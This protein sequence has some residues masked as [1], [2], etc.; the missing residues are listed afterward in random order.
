MSASPF[1]TLFHSSNRSARV[2]PLWNTATLL[3][4]RLWNKNIVWGVS[5]ISGTITIT[6]RPSKITSSIRRIKTEVFPLPVTPYNKDTSNLPLL[7]DLNKSLNAA[8][9]SVDSTIFSDDSELSTWLYG[10]RYISKSYNST[11]PFLTNALT[12]AGVTPAK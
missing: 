3:P 2:N 7:Y 8:C 11:T 12:T 5:D 1:L 10:F 6:E 4:Y 9:C